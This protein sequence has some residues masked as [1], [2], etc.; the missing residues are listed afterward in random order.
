VHPVGS[1]CTDCLN[2]SNWWYWRTQKNDSSR[3][4]YRN[5]SG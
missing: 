4:K 3:H 5:A 1:Y 2:H